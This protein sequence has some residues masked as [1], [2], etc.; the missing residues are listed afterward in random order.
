[1]T[2]RE[3]DEAAAAAELN[4]PDSPG[5]Q[6]DA[7]EASASPA[8]RTSEG[9]AQPDQSRQEAVSADQPQSFASPGAGDIGEF[10]PHGKPLLVFLNEVA[11]GR[12]LLQTVRERVPDVSQIAVVSPQ[13]QP[14]VAGQR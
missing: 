8:E 7:T 4:E 11:G 13:N 12:K 10:N 2:E 9:G 5:A 3:P 14:A 1:M 6:P